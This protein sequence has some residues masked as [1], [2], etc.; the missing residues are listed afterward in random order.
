MSENMFNNKEEKVT[1]GEIVNENILE[2]DETGIV[3]FDAFQPVVEAVDLIQ[4]SIPIEQHIH[5]L[6]RV[7][8]T[9]LS[10]FEHQNDL[11]VL[12]FPTLYPNGEN[13]FGTIREVKVTPLEYFQTRLLS[14]DSRR[15]CHPAYNFWA[16]NI[17]EALKLQSSI[18]IAMRMRSFRIGH[19]EKSNRETKEK[20]L[21]TADLLRGCLENNPHLRENC[22]NLM[23]DIRGTQAYWN[24]V[25]IQLFAMFCT[26]GPPTFFVTLSADDNNW[27]DLMIVLSKSKGQNL[28]EE[29][30]AN[31]SSSK[32]RELMRTNPVVT[33]RHFAHRFQC[34]LW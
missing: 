18:S 4:G 7:T 14:A 6:Q 3:R 34:F 2:M 13:G 20:E 9:P 25:K 11:E 28:S 15:G 31:L 8:T 19:C 17:E 27:V 26:L 32:R 1:D 23:R 33:A 24:S 21:L 5:K 16:C 10:I 12:A 29:Q 30:A 22:H